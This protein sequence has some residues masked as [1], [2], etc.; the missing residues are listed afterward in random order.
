MAVRSDG[1]AAGYKKPKTPHQP[2]PK[3][4]APPARPKSVIKPVGSLQKVAAYRPPTPT[5]AAKN[6]AA[7]GKYSTRK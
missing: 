5:Q 1:G 3:M 2:A 4:T 7:L 6:R